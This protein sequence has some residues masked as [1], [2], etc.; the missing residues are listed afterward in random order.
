M[1]VPVL[2]VEGLSVEFP[3][4]GGRGLFKPK[5]TFKALSEISLSLVAGEALGLIGESGSGKT[6]LGKA[7]VGLV[8][9]SQGRIE[10]AGTELD[11]QK[12]A[13]R[14]ALACQV[15]M[16]FQDPFSS[17]HPRKTVGNTLSEP[18]RIQKTVE[19]SAQPGKVAALLQRVGL[20]PAHA[21]RYPQHFS[22]GQ[23]QRIAIAR[24]I[25]N[26]PS[27][28]VADEPVSAL[29]V[30]VQAQILNLLDELKAQENMAML[31]ISHDLS[32][33]RHLCQR[34]AVMYLG[35]IV[36]I[37][38]AKAMAASP[39]HPYTAALMSAVPRVKAR[40]KAMSKPIVLKGDVPSHAAIP[41]GCPFHTRCWLYAKKGQ[42][43]RC[44][45]EVPDLVGV[46]AD[47]Q[48][49]CFFP[50]EADPSAAGA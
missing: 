48:S 24:A 8:P 22:G 10:V 42:P 28:L 31:F 39:V 44:R 4:S 29:D 15:Q 49:A 25:A 47:R 26:Q 41:S 9:T 16:V 6:T 32:V 33:V 13:D 21:A 27:V 38:P 30:S 2:R 18:F 37:G 14:S 12:D 34:I 3:A 43:E 1:S 20:D 5:T 23:R 19:S 7:I 50:Q 40:N 46:G 17:L 35:R 11:V 36:E 45:S